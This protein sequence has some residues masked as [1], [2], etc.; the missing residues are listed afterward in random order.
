MTMKKLILF[1]L[2][3]LL[4]M[5]PLFTGCMSSDT[6]IIDGEVAKELENRINALAYDEFHYLRGSPPSNI[7]NGGELLLFENELDI[8]EKMEFTE[9]ME[10]RYLQQLPMQ[11][12][13]SFFTQ[14]D[15]VAE[16]N[17]PM[18][19]RIGDVIYFLETYPKSLNVKTFSTEKLTDIEATAFEFF[20]GIGYFSDRNGNIFTFDPEDGKVSQLLFEAGRLLSID[21]S[22]IYA[23]YNEQSIAV[24]DR[25]SL[26]EITRIHG[27]PFHDIQISGTYIFYLDGNTLMRHSLL[28]PEEVEKASVLE[29]AEYA[30]LDHSLVIAGK[31][32]GL[33]VSYLDGTGIR[34]L[35][36]DTASSIHLTP[37]IVFYRNGYDMDQWYA[38][39]LSTGHRFAVAGE[40]MTDG[41][42]HFFPLSR[43][44]N[45]LAQSFFTDLILTLEAGKAPPGLTPIVEGSHPVFVDIRDPDTLKFFAY[46][47]SYTLPEEIDLIVTISEK[48]TVIGRYTD[49][50]LAYRTDTILSLYTLSSPRP[51]LTLIQQGL[52]PIEVKHG[53][54]DRYGVPASWHPKALEIQH[55]IEK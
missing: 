49:N 38:V 12:I 23:L 47:N 30:L 34:K 28:S 21:S 22:R 8:I 16:V 7:R 52:P 42:I 13:D 3:P 6:L 27:G 44:K 32:K 36:D 40:T 33:Y 54:G 2:T 55:L 11:Y 51:I 29:V 45:S 9:E 14:Y 20:E 5:M 18:V 24:Y 10:L 37:D 1:L 31:E 19:V 50:Y 4:L 46:H 39:R 25:T 53:K 43:E 41:G 35:S 26:L 48:K 15:Y 17:G